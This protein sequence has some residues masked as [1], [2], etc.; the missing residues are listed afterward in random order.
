[1]QIE[2]LIKEKFNKFALLIK[3]LEFEF[4]KCAFY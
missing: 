3:D 4:R 1:M 2:K